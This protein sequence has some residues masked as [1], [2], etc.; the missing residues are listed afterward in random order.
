[1]LIFKHHTPSPVLAMMR[2]VAGLRLKDRDTVTDNYRQELASIEAKRRQAA[3]ERAEH[4]AKVAEQKQQYAS[5]TNLVNSALEDL[6]KG[7]V[8]KIKAIKDS[9][10]QQTW[11]LFCK[12]FPLHRSIEHGKLRPVQVLLNPKEKDLNNPKF[13]IDYTVAN[14]SYPAAY[15]MAL[16]LNEDLSVEQNRIRAAMLERILKDLPKFSAEGQLQWVLHAVIIQPELNLINLTIPEQHGLTAAMQL[17]IDNHMAAL[18]TMDADLSEYGEDFNIKF[19]K[20]DEYGRTIF[21]HALQHGHKELSLWLLA[22]TKLVLSPIEQACIEGN[23]AEVE[24]L[25]AIADDSVDPEIRENT[26]LLWAIMHGHNDI[27]T[28]LLASNR[29]DVTANDNIA[30]ITAIRYGHLNIAKQ[31]LT[32]GSEIT[33]QNDL[34]LHFAKTLD[35]DRLI[36]H[37]PSE[38]RLKKQ[39][40]LDF[41]YQ[42]QAMLKEKQL[43]PTK[44]KIAA[45]NIQYGWI[46]YKIKGEESDA[47][48]TLIK[49]FNNDKQDIENLPT[50]N[51]FVSA[52]DKIRKAKNG[53]TVSISSIEEAR[54]IIKQGGMVD[55]ANNLSQHDGPSGRMLA[56]TAPQIY[57]QCVRLSFHW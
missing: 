23:V 37:T 36:G 24:R 14:E 10:N 39:S 57:L 48:Q 32:A 27:V 50:H 46:S 34:A 5:N 3:A 49:Q 26:P 7:I 15:E 1:M 56:Q 19:N 53:E 17:A 35:T 55:V 38:L 8:L 43:L 11:D 44:Q 54:E 20:T 47:R 41:I 30:I 4:L 6:D 52:F 28:K 16:S 22:K 51:T 21:D 2:E 25:L 29:V 42:T 40:I 45:T 13:Y 18:I 33:A 31:L 12:S 9:N